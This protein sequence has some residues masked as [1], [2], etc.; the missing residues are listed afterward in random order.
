MQETETVLSAPGYL[1]PDQPPLCRAVSCV[2]VWLDCDTRKDEATQRRA[3]DMAGSTI[4]MLSYRRADSPV[5]LA[6]SSDMR[7]VNDGLHVMHNVVAVEWPT[8]PNSP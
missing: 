1:F 2:V 3:S 6:R 8:R 4:T 5:H 7:C